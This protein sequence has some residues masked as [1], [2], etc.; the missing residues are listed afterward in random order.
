M[1][2]VDTIADEQLFS[3][4]NNTHLE[5]P[6]PELLNVSGLKLFRLKSGSYRFERKDQINNCESGNKCEKA[7]ES[8]ASERIKMDSREK[9]CN[10]N[11]HM[12]DKNHD[13]IKSIE[14]KYANMVANN[15][16][17]NEECN[18]TDKEQLSI[19]DKS[20]KIKK[21]NKQNNKQTI[22]LV[23]ELQSATTNQVHSK[24]EDK[25]VLDKHVIGNERIQIL[26]SST[27]VSPK[28]LSHKKKQRFMKTFIMKTNVYR[29][30]VTKVQEMLLKAVSL[31][32]IIE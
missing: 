3:C 14:P 28:D 21:A 25:C 30:K 17:K 9:Q 7:T 26:K 4:K 15:V 2:E 19:A 22:D 29:K 5:T 10:R 8:I 27:K 31:S 18:Q 32:L 23:R 24:G 13:W 11:E 12:S 1:K 6:A 16:H 20:Q